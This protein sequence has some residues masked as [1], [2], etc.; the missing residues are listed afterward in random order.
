MYG[1]NN[2]SLRCS[3]Q[4]QLLLSSVKRIKLI[5]TNLCCPT[6]VFPAST[7]DPHTFRIFSNLFSNWS[8]LASS[9]SNKLLESNG[10][11]SIKSTK[12]REIIL[13]TYLNFGESRRHSWRSI[14]Q[15]TILRM[16]I[17]YTHHGTL[18]ANNRNPLNNKLS[19]TTRKRNINEHTTHQPLSYFRQPRR[20]TNWFQQEMSSRFW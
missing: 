8:T 9:S 19:H 20:Q 11:S 12:F 13:K 18:H 16:L 7:M 6:Y 5:N 17:I 2:Y 10:T 3:E 1:C 4:I 15:T 14:L